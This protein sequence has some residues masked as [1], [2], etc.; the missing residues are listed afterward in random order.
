MRGNGAAQVSVCAG[1]KGVFRCPV[2]SPAWQRSCADKRQVQPTQHSHSACVR[3]CMRSPPKTT[4]TT[5]AST[6]H[7]SHHN[8][9]LLT[10]STAHTMACRLLPACTSPSHT[11]HQCIDHG[12]CTAVSVVCT[13]MYGATPPL[14]FG[15]RSGQAAGVCDLTTHE[16]ASWVTTWRGAPAA[17]ARG[18]VMALM[19][20]A[21]RP[22][23][24]H[25]RPHMC[26]H[27]W[28]PCSV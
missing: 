10:P 7:G 13:L 20:H 8:H 23:V 9:G 5:T 2:A 18:D 19:A 6:R 1:E 24:S 22:A 3:A 16:G 15:L 26:L 12:D 21:A 4:S 27:T 17:G 28:P 11:H 14:R 25:A